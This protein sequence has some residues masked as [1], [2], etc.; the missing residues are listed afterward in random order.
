MLIRCIKLSIY[1][2]LLLFAAKSIGIS[3]T[4]RTNPSIS[5]QDFS[6]LQLSRWQSKTKNIVSITQ[7]RWY[8]TLIGA[9]TQVVFRDFQGLEKS[10]LIETLGSE[11]NNCAGTFHFEPP[12]ATLQSDIKAACID[13]HDFQRNVSTLIQSVIEE[14]K[15]HQ[16]KAMQEHVTQERN[17][18]SWL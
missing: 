13:K 8:W 15:Q 5:E 10:L 11:W 16:D 7:G 1:A 6:P 12:T 2:C 17:I 18:R 3:D 4:Y 9:N 14:V